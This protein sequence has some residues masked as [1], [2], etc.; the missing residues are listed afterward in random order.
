MEKNE[1]PPPEGPEV[2]RSADYLNRLLSQRRIVEVS[3]RGGRY[4][5][6]PPQGFDEFQKELLKP[7]LTITGVDCKGKFLYWKVHPDWYVWCTYGMS[8]QWNESPSDHTAIAIL[9]RT[10]RVGVLEDCIPGIYFNDPRHYGTVKFVKD[11]GGVKTK[12][13]LD[14]LGPDMLSD[15]PNQETFDLRLMKRAKKTIAEALMDQ[16]VISGVGNYIKA[17]ALYLSEIS[18][19]RIVMMLKEGERKQLREQII[20]VMKASYSTGGATFRTYRNVDGSRGEAARRFVIYNNK[21]DPM[22]NP[23]VK[24][25]TKDGRTTHWVP[26]IQK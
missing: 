24:E 25:E 26:S 22:G 5:S 3:V 20:N 17:E 9:H 7:Q 12:K 13:K 10:T 15:P 18:P 21:T 1:K 2:R 14:S 11:P 16:S 4:A 19:H 23:V 6:S 8:G